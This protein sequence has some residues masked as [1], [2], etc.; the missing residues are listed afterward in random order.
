[1]EEKNIDIVECKYQSKI[2][3]IIGDIVKTYPDGSIF[4][5]KFVAH[6]FGEYTST[7][8][9]ENPTPDN[10]NKCKGKWNTGNRLM[11]S[12]FPPDEDNTDKLCSGGFVKCTYSNGDIYMKEIGCH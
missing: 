4:D 6:G 7:T 1:M 12:V 8:H 10:S 5:G 3:Y 2:Q 11:M 9:F